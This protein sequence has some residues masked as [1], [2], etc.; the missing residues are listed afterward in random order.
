[1]ST[2]RP[3]W[4]APTRRRLAAA[5]SAVAA[6]L[7]LAAC[8]GS[9]GT[10]GSGSGD[11]VT[12]GT[13]DKVYALDPAGSFDAGSGAVIAQVYATLLDR[14]AGS[15]VLK[16]NLAASA[17]FTAPKVYKVVLK[18]GLKFAN[19]NALTSQDVKFSFDRQLKIAS[20]NGPSSLLY[21]LDRVETPDATTVLF[22]LKAANDQV[23]PQVLASGA[24]E[25][26]DNT[27]FSP[28]A[29]TPDAAIVAKKPFAGPY[30]IGSFTA[31]QLVQFRANPNYQGILGKPSFPTVNLKYYA[32]EDNLKLDLQQGGVDLATRTLSITNL[33]SL[34]KQKGL[35]VYHGAATGFRYLVFN[36]KTQPY[37]TGTSQADPKKALAVRQAVAHAIDRSGLAAQ[38]Y[39]NTYQPVYTFL[40]DAVPTGSPVLKGLYG[41]G[42]GGP[43]K[44]KAAAVLKAAGVTT[45]VTLQLQYNTDHYGASSSDEFA[46]VK[47]QLES[48]GLFTVKLQSTD[49]TQYA[50]QRVA[51]AY[52]EFQLGWFAD[53]LDAQDFFQPLYGKNGFI[54][55]HYEDPALIDLIDQQATTPGDDKRAALSLRIQQALA[56]A[57]PIVPLLQSSSNA[58]ADGRVGGVQEALKTGGLPFGALKKAS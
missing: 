45:P 13:T 41:D 42:N 40:P 43:D 49:W 31:N 3:R 30:T 26:V 53:Y 32:L 50:K 48:T 1:M 55:N 52:P 44:A 46:L 23:F 39:K 2:P 10:A 8:G 36:F 4:A 24:G 51:D 37:G 14:P 12:I 58:V 7:L 54:G 56:A 33:D 5:A 47:N 16:P 22:H 19:G 21:D 25:I 57:L 6:S 15:G 18:P 28:T 9:D 34:S 27:V 29:V 38:V 20:T 11:T 17:G 35:T